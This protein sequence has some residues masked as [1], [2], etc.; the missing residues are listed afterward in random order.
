MRRGMKLTDSSFPVRLAGVDGALVCVALGD[1]HLNQEVQRTRVQQFL[2]AELALVQGAYEFMHEV[3]VVSEDGGELA[4]MMGEQ[5]CEVV[6]A[7]VDQH[8]DH[9]IQYVLVFFQGGDASFQ[10]AEVLVLEP[11]PGDADDLPRVHEVVGQLGEEPA[12]PADH[13]LVLGEEPRLV[14]IQYQ[15]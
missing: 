15:I 4:H 8:W 11:V 2:S 5:L 14:R 9:A 3:E 6:L 13:F 1:A 7:E 12:A 10:G